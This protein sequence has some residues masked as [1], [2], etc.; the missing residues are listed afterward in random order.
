MK[1]IVVNGVAQSGKDKFVSFFKSV[2]NGELRVKNYSSIDRVKQIAEIC[3]GWNGKKDDKSRRLLSE[4]KKVWTDYNDGPF[5]TINKKI[6]IDIEYSKNKGKDTSKNIYFLH[7]R[8]PNEISKIEKFYGSDCVTL[9][10]KK[11]V[12]F[13]PDNDSD[14]NVEKYD[15]DY[16]VDNNKSEKELKNRADEFLTYIKKTL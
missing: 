6:K 7:V 1:I 2:S 5:N 4:M 11:S 10:V 16:I 15:Y 13:V 3:F 12:D 9:L 14:K 8:E